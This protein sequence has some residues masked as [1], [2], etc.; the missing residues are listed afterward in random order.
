MTDASLSCLWFPALPSTQ[1]HA[2]SLIADGQLASTT[3][4][5]A[6]RQD[7]GEGTQGR[8]WLST[9]GATLTFTLV[10]PLPLATPEA[11]AAFRRLPVTALTTRACLH[12]LRQH[13]PEPA[14]QAITHKPIN[15]LLAHNKK[16]LG[17][18][19]Q[20]IAPFSLPANDKPAMAYRIIGVG[21]NIFP[22]NQALP[23][24]T[25]YDAIS[26]AELGDLPESWQNF[27]ATANS[28]ASHIL[29]HLIAAA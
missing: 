1:Q 13:L 18:L 28:L 12:W 27:Q 2:L 16:L 5:G 29:Y 26:L 23:E 22:L 4:I 9:P 15:D 17:C 20:T 11:L 24:G 10:Q 25:P 3:L 6:D 14:A 8:R 7:A 19:T 21:L